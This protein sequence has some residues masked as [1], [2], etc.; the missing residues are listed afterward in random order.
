MAEQACQI[1]HVVEHDNHH[2]DE[3]RPQTEQ[4][5]AHARGHRHRAEMLGIDLLFRHIVQRVDHYEM[6]GQFLQLDCVRHRR[7]FRFSLQS[8]PYAAGNRFGAATCAAKIKDRTNRTMMMVQFTQ[9]FQGLF[10]Y[11]PSSSLSLSKSCRKMM[12]EGN[13]TPASTCTP[14]MISCSGARGISTSPAAAATLT[15]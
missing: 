3:V 6:V 4:R 14:K 12:A 8:P 1:Q 11:S 13:I 15:R 10:A 2:Q 5:N 9:L 7:H